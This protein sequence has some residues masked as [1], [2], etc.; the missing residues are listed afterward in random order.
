MAIANNFPEAHMTASDMDDVVT[1]L[2]APTAN[3]QRPIIYSLQEQIIGQWIDGRPLYQRSY[4]GTVQHEG[5][6]NAEYQYN[7]AELPYDIE[8]VDIKGVLFWEGVYDGTYPATGIVQLNWVSGNYILNKSGGGYASE[9]YKMI[10]TTKVP[11]LNKHYL[12]MCTSGNNI[13]QSF[14]ATIQYVKPL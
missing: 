5:A 1:P 14:V 13:G 12:T 4:Q 11:A 10:W 7:F 9:N 3:G 6:D 8:P 2:P